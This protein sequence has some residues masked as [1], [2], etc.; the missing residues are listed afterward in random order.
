MVDQEWL[1]SFTPIQTLLCDTVNFSK[2]D[3]LR[4]SIWID[5][6]SE[7]YKHFRKNYI[8]EYKH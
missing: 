2:A 7:L 8:T 6:I 3:K 5:K 1:E 4:G